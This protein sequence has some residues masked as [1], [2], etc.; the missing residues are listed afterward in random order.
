[1]IPVWIRDDEPFHLPPEVERV[2]ED[3]LKGYPWRA[4]ID[5]SSKHCDNGDIKLRIWL[6]GGGGQEPR[7]IKVVWLLR[8]EVEPPIKPDI[9]VPIGTWFYDLW[10]RTTCY[11]FCDPDEIRERLEKALQEVEA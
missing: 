9:V 3:V 2:L 6:H 8:R 11:Q 4:D 7:Q 10:F 5:I 1:M